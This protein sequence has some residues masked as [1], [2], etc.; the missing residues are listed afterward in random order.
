MDGVALDAQKRRGAERT[1]RCRWQRPDRGGPPCGSNG[2]SQTKATATDR[3]L[4]S[5]CLECEGLEEP[6]RRELIG[7]LFLLHHLRWNKV[8]PVLVAHIGDLMQQ[9]PTD[10]AIKESVIVR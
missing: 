7:V 6:L 8:S 9:Y 5:C 4:N 1:C 10:G 3:I 2:S